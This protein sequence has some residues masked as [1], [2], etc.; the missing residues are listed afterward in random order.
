MMPGP[1]GIRSRKTGR[2]LAVVL[3]G[4]VTGTA[5]RERQRVGMTEGLGCIRSQKIDC[6]MMQAS[7]II[8]VMPIP[9]ATL[10]AHRAKM[11]EE[12]GYIRRLKGGRVVVAGTKR[13]IG[14]GVQSGNG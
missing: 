11:M 6:D 1:E 2:A 14:A 10:A 5:N 8:P 12:P 13:L 7:A 3:R 9:C 4:R